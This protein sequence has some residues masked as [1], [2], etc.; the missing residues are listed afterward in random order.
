MPIGLMV[1]VEGTKGQ[2]DEKNAFRFEISDLSDLVDG[3]LMRA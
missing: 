2:I 1:E 3:M